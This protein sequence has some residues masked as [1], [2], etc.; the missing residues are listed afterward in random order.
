MLGCDVHLRLLILLTYFLSSLHIAGE[1][2][3]FSD[4]A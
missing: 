4:W 1:D 2:S 3:V